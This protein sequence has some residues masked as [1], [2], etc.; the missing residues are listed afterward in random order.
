[1]LRAEVA[2]R[3]V[4]VGVAYLSWVDT[5]MVRGGDEDEIFAE[6]RRRL[7][8]PASRTSS[9]DAAVSRLVA[10]ISRRSAHVYVPA[11]VR[12]VQWLPRG[13][14]P[15]LASQQGA[16]E[17]ARFA[18]RLDATA[19]TRLAPVGPGGRAGS[20]AAARSADIIGQ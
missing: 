7:P 2:H 18:S 13:L 9:L 4:R 11:W 19:Q 3:G 6:Q 8:W 14:M 15:A 10:G 20:A 5:D 1:M 17:V 16:R 12:V